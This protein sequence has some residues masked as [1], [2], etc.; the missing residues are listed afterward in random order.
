MIQNP[1]KVAVS[2]TSKWHNFKKSFGRISGGDLRTMSRLTY[3]SAH[4]SLP[5]PA[6]VLCCEHPL[7]LFS[8]WILLCVFKRPDLVMKLIL[9]PIWY[10]IVMFIHLL[11]EKRFNLRRKGIACVINVYYVM[12]NSIISTYHILLWSSAWGGWVGWGM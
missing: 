4:E 12:R 6:C 9:T 7:V 2:L 10:H 8:F 11:E 1:W 3:W 5:L